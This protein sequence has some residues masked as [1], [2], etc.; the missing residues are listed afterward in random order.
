L[1]EGALDADDVDSDFELATPDDE[2]SGDEDDEDHE[3]EEPVIRIAEFETQIT[4]DLDLLEADVIER[5]SDSNRLILKTEQLRAL[6]AVITDALARYEY[7][8][9]EVVAY[10]FSVMGVMD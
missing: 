7:T 6:I 8:E 4:E 1:I 5:D 2:R 9:S 3:E 10:T